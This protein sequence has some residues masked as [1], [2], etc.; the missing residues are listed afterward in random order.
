MLKYIWKC[1]IKSHCVHL[2]LKHIG[3]FLRLT[4]PFNFNGKFPFSSSWWAHYCTVKSRSA[5]CHQNQCLTFESRLSHAAAAAHHKQEYSG[6]IPTQPR[7][8]DAACLSQIFLFQHEIFPIYIINQLSVFL[9][10]NICVILSR[11]QASFTNQSNPSFRE[12]QIQILSIKGRFRKKKVD[13][14]FPAVGGV[15]RKLETF[16]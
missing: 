16:Y 9:Y 7:A 4:I 13:E 3:V 14:I 12:I 5:Q 15:G 6:K 11:C 1:Q 8:G 10:I 2:I